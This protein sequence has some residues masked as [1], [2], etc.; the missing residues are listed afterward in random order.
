MYNVEWTEFKT[1]KNCDKIEQTRKDNLVIK[2]DALIV[3]Q[4]L[5]QPSKNQ[6]V[7]PKFA[8]LGLHLLRETD[9]T[10]IS[11]SSSA[12]S[13]IRYAT[14]KT[15]TAAIRKKEAREGRCSERGR[16]SPL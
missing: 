13:D 2:R 12:R 15:L 16:I 11:P 9:T 4:K 3:T 1:Q 8:F 14:I 7:L 10:P 5:S 6:G